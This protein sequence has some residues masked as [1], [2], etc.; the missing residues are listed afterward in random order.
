MVLFSHPEAVRDVFRLEPEIA[1]AGQSWEFLP[2][3]AGRTQLSRVVLAVAG[4]A[5][6]HVLDGAVRLDSALAVAV[7]VQLGGLDHRPAGQRCARAA[8]ATH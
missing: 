2:P 7:V 5:A 8:T 4:S 3:F 1:S 6:A